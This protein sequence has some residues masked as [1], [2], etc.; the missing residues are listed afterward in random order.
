MACEVINVI[1]LI[2]RLYCHDLHHFARLAFFT[3]SNKAN[4][5]LDGNRCQVHFLALTIRHIK[6]IEIQLEL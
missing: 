5:E 6:G 4:L 3:L 2:T 1:I